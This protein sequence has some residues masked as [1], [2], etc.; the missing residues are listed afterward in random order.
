MAV[1]AGRAKAVAG[2]GDRLGEQVAPG[3]PAK[4]AVHHAEPRDT[5]PGTETDSGPMRGMPPA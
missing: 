3:Q 5:V 4:S 2:I 1:G